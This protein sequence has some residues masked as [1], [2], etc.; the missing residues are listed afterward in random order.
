[1]KQTIIMALSMITIF[2]L[3]M[4][5]NY[6]QNLQSA[7]DREAGLTKQIK[8]YESMLE[9]ELVADKLYYKRLLTELGK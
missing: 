1:M 5:H 8:E 7:Y 4:T 6:K 3:L 9:P 2:S